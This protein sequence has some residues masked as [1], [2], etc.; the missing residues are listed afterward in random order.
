MPWAAQETRV[1]RLL[2][3]Q[4]ANWLPADERDALRSAFSRELDRLQ[5]S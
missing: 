4:M 5:A 1:N 2:F 3:H